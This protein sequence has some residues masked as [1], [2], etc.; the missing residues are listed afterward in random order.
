MRMDVDLAVAAREILGGRLSLRQ[1]LSG[2]AP[3]IEPAIFASDDLL[4]GAVELGLVEYMALRRA[5]GR[6]WGPR[7][8][9]ENESEQRA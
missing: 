2:F 7:L 1:Y 6:V 4:P 9:H 5:I 3:G 8:R